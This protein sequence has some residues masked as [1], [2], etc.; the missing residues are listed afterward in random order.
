MVSRRAAKKAREEFEKACLEH[1]DALYAAALKLTRSPSEAEEL[2]QNTYLKAFRFAHKFEWGTNLKAWLFRIQTN[3][4]IN[5]YRH[6]GQERRYLERAAAEPIYDEVFDREAQAF[7]SNPETH[8]FSRFFQED[9]ERALQD[10][11]E[12]FRIVIVLADIEGFSYKEIADITECPIGTVM[13]R[14]HRARRI[15]QRALVD[16][17]VEAGIVSQNSEIKKENNPT[18]ISAYR[19][20]KKG[21]L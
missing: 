20:Y 19:K 18:D 11:P 5:E 17:A 12:D 9:L 15:L 6:Q 4:F 10:L 14:L 3:G 2:V 13:S 7:A 8:A 16:Y 1:L 21:S